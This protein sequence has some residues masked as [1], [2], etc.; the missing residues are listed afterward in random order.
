MFA[1]KLGE[2]VIHLPL[3]KIA[4]FFLGGK[5]NSQNQPASQP[6]G[7]QPEGMSIARAGWCPSSWKPFS[8]ETS[9]YSHGLKGG[10]R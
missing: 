3:L 2:K 5:V 1:A 6:V 4:E 9:L 8:L 10:A 7:D